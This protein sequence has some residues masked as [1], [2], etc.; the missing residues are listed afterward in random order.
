VTLTLP[1]G[2]RAALW[3]AVASLTR[4]CKR[5]ELGPVWLAEARED[6]ALVHVHGIV[7]EPFPSSRL[8]LEGWRAATK[9]LAMMART[10]DLRGVNEQRGGLIGWLGY[11]TRGVSASELGEYVLA[12]G[13][14]LEPWAEILGSA[15]VAQPS[16]CAW[17][18]WPLAPEQIRRGARF[19]RKRCA[20]QASR[21]E[22]RGK[23]TVAQRSN[24]STGPD[25]ATTLLLRSE[26]TS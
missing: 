14:W 8:L 25:I 1:G 18:L 10:V 21:Q 20:Q 17:C 5:Y 4:F 22:R 12:S 3:R 15:T 9:G 26:V 11:A 24:A 6:G 13:A 23:A 2:N 16:R 7:G 19:H